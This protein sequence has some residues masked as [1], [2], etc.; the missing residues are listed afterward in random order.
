M[1]TLHTLTTVASIFVLLLVGYGAKKLGALKAADAS[2]INSIIVNITMP[3]FIF[4]SIHGKELTLPM[5]KTPF[6]GFAA[7]L[8]VMGLAYLAAKVMRMDRRTT[9]ALMLVS[10]FG[11]TGFLGLAVILRAFHSDPQALFGAIMF[12]EFAMTFGLYSVGVIV[13][14]AFGGSKFERAHMMEFARSPL[15]WSAVVGL[16]FR[17]VAL[18]A[19][20]MQTI[21]ILAKATVPL[22]MISI[23]LSLSSRSV[24]SNLPGI[25]ATFV[26]KM[27]ALPLLVY[28]TLPHVGVQG[29]VREAATLEAAMPAAILTGV[30]SARYGANGAFA[31]AAIFATTL[32]AI[33]WLPLVLV[34]MR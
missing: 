12:D 34:L 5:I 1:E 2:V 4:S 27:I 30:V 31:A 20:L 25:A 29:I 22:A 28:L 14:A 24:K 6:I 9:G 11:N 3:P 15:I 17:Q 8:V 26:L 19:M 10:A 33:V 32:A 7:Q 18:P 21:E 16:V 13:A 23:G